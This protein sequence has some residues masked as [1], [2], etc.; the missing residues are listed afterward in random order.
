MSKVIPKEQLA[1]MQPL[2]LAAFDR[3]AKPKSH[4]AHV[5][6]PAKAV[7]PKAVLAEL[8]RMREAARQEGFRQG[9]EDGRKTG[10]A[11]GMKS[12]HEHLERLNSLA[13]E[14]DASRIREDQTLARD[15]LNLALVVAQ[16]IVRGEIRVH[17][18]TILGAIR[19]AMLAL[20]GMEV[21][22][23]ILTHPADADLVRSW[24]ER[25]HSH[26]SWEVMGDPRLQ[27]GGFRIESAHSELDASLPTRWQQVIETMGA[28]LGWL[29]PNA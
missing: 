1:N 27:Q 24:L 23:H 15:I 14:L 11:E 18:E 26:L 12:A 10:Y 28:D 2:K 20:P 13:A 29:E 21:Q 25:E 8:E 4:A 16:Q 22:Y 9:S 6:S 19:E 7:P 3:P 5:S 17:P